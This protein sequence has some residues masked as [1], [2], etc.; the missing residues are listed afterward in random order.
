MKSLNKP[1]IIFVHTGQIIN[2]Q[3]QTSTFVKSQAESLAGDYDI[4]WFLLENNTSPIK[5][6]AAIKALK[7]LVQNNSTIQLLHAH[8]GSITAFIA[9]QAAGNMPLIVSFGG[10]DLLGTVQPGLKWRI[11]ETLAKQFSYY[12]ARNA[13]SIIVKSKN[14]KEALPKS[15]ITKANII[16]NGVNTELFL[17]GN[18]QAARVALG[19]ASDKKYILFNASKGNNIPVKNRTLAEA[20]IIVLQQKFP[21]SELLVVSGVPQQ[22]LVLIMQASDALILTSLHEGSPN[23]VKEAM[24]CNLPVVSV[25]CGDVEER[26]A[27]TNTGGFFDYTPEKLANGLRK[28]FEYSGVYNGR[29]EIFKQGLDHIATAKKVA[30]VYQQTISTQ[31]VS[32]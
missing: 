16:P 4:E 19:L 32:L 29:E 28:V 30:K 21:E 1:K 12:A 10:D 27:N 26:L 13:N 14:L 6:S 9:T 11:R 15:T 20:T 3:V 17:P 18:K 23:V 2:G 31:V 25:R 5:I 24:A 22:E 8:Y 7:K